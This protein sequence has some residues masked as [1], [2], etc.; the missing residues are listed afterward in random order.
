M[1]TDVYIAIIGSLTIVNV[2]VMIINLI[3]CG[4]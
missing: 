3:K 4:K 1:K 2:I